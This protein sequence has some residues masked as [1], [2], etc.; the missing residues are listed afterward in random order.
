MDEA[1]ISRGESAMAVAGVIIHGD[2]QSTSIQKKLAKL[3]RKHIPEPD[4]LGFVFHATDIYHGARYF[5]RRKWQWDKRIEI[6]SDLASIIDEFHLPVVVGAYVKETFGGGAVPADLAEQKKIGLMQSAATMD[7]AVQADRW[8]A[9]YSP[10]ENALLIAED[11][12]RVKPLIK[13][14]IL[15]L[16]Y[17][18]RLKDAGLDT[19]AKDFN[20]PLRRIIDTVHFAAKPDCA[21]LQLADLCAFCIARVSKGK[22]VPPEVLDPITRHAGWIRDSWPDAVTG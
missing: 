19:F 9:K 22:D 8:L 7:C 11:A 12:D 5:D 16:R 3:I 2:Q 21:P 18:D 20:L 6:L 13:L 1:G 10:D 17:P 15:T 14:I 4:Q